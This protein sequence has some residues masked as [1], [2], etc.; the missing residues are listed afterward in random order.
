MEDV[1][2]WTFSQGTRMTSLRRSHYKIVVREDELL[3]YSVLKKL[4][5]TARQ[6]L[7]PKVVGKRVER[8]DAAQRAVNFVFIGKRLGVAK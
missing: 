7:K 4:Q 8:F 5:C 2:A 1:D 3:E 6:M